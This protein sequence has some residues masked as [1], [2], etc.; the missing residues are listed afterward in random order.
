VRMWKFILAASL[1]L[2][3]QSQ[4]DEKI[5][6]VGSCEIRL[7]PTGRM[8]IRY[9]ALPLINYEMLQ[10]IDKSKGWEGVYTYGKSGKVQCDVSREGG[11]L[12]ISL[13]ERAEGL[14][15]LTKNIEV[16][17][18]EIRWTV[19]YE[20]ERAAPELWN[21]YFLDI[22]QAL[23]RRGCYEIRTKSGV[24]QGNFS[25]GIRIPQCG[26]VLAVRITTQSVILEFGLG[27]E[28]V[29]WKFTDWTRTEHRS[30]RLRIEKEATKRIKANASVSL[31]VRESS[32]EILAAA[33]EAARKAREERRRERLKALGFICRGKLAIGKVAKNRDV[34]G[35]YRKFELTFPLSG[36]F[37]NPFDPDEIDV[38]CHFTAPSG[39]KLK[40]PAFFYQDYERL[41]D[42][43][44]E[45]KG[46]PV[47][48]VRFAP[49]EV[50]EYRYYLTARNK[51][52]D[53]KTAVE[54]FKCVASPE[55]G[56]IRISGKNPR[57]FE[58]DSGEPYIP[59]GVNLFIP[60]RLGQPI[61]ADR[62]ERCE[63]IMRNL[64]ENGGNFVRLRNDSW[65]LAIEMTPDEETG[66]LGLGYYNQ[67]TCQE[68]DLIYSIARLHGIYIMH[69][70]DNANAN[71]NLGEPEGKRNAWRR[72][73][74]HYLR[75]NGGVLETHREFWTNAGVERY[76][77]NRLRY[78]AARWGY[79]TNLMCYEFWN[80]VN[81]FDEHLESIVN[82]HRD[83]ARYLRSIDI[84]RHP[85]TTSV[86]GH[87]E[88]NAARIFLLPEIEIA[89]THLYA[90]SPLVGEVREFYEDY[91]R[92]YKK[93]F[94]LGEFGLA[95]DFRAPT[96]DFDDIGVHIHN[97]FWSSLFTG[98]SGAGAPW[99]VESYMLPKGLFGLFRPV[100]R[101][102]GLV[103]WTDD[104]LRPASFSEMRFL[105]EPRE[106]HYVDFTLPLSRK[107]AF[108]RPPVSRFVVRRDGTI[109]NGS[110][111]QPTLFAFHSRG[112]PPTFVVDFAR[113]GRFV[114]NVKM[115]IGDE[116]NKLAIYLDGKKVVE[117]PFPA[118]KEYGL[119]SEYV[120]RYDN[121][122]TRYDERVAIDV[123]AG[124]HE[125]RPVMT[126]KD[127]MIVSYI[128]ENY[129]CFEKSKPLRVMGFRAGETAYLWVH[130]KS[131]NWRWRWDGKEPIAIERACVDLL[132]MP[133]GRY[134]VGWWDTWRGGFFREE[135]CLSNGKTLTL[136]IPRVER[137]VAC[138]VRKL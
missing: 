14:I 103:P 18:E 16:S 15:S 127:H 28:N 81:L 99:Y 80:E 32:P 137:D 43:N 52:G 40:V 21:Y 8:S 120:E 125:I 72:I 11:L 95:P 19:R 46:E 106:L 119:G 116:R 113:R 63:R 84:N 61:P 1:C 41:P 49:T 133:R 20:T 111:I 48:K 132:D 66:Y 51:T 6:T 10:L 60:T 89:Q 12:K 79:S 26:D 114:V 45:R 115:S 68:I 55:K 86:G 35:R 87:R 57:C 130:N 50:G 33:V 74:D 122:R 34:V 124:R 136:K 97:G 38:V 27:G 42:G 29:N 36:A 92:P 71:V 37:D 44:F 9:G 4:P 3:A 24:L 108:Q 78:C 39:R 62:L 110:M 13:S 100:S 83:M 47:W 107:W 85:I 102:A 69:C 112:E 31:R 53:V 58:F 2:F 30:Y 94:F 64:A 76:V 88:R 98:M 5:F 67:R 17:E 91:A 101:F 104:D 96:F 118:G 75:E 138:V 7:D 70:L 134:S 129:L 77:R 121:W 73:Y 135:E 126:G 22:P 123:P 117:K 128:L 131:S 54:S 82:W 93:P 65:F 56:F 105:K 109:D 90:S 59:M 25:E 23:L